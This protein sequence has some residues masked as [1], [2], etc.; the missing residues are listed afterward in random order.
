MKATAASPIDVIRQQHWL[1]LS[2]YLGQKPA[3]IRS[4]MKLWFTILGQLGYDLV[5]TGANQQTA[6]PAVIPSP[7]AAPESSYVDLYHAVEDALIDVTGRRNNGERISDQAEVR[8]IVTKVQA[9][10]TR[11]D[12][13]ISTT[14]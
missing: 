9:A 12:P 7:P 8:E 13:P 6:R 1:E 14:S 10:L 3:T 2:D 11:A 5:A 4:T